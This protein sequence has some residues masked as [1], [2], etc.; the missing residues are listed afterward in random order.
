MKQIWRLPLASRTELWNAVGYTPSAEQL[1]AH[2]DPHRLK[3]VSGGE[4]AGKSFWTAHEL[5]TWL[6]TAGKDDLFWLVGP[7]YELARPEF[8]HLL[9]CYAG[10]G[11][12]DQSSVQTPATGQWNMQTRGGAK[13]ETKTSADIKKLAGVAPTGIAMTE[14]AQQDWEAFIR[15]RGRV[16]QK[17]G[18][19]IMSGTQESS[20][21]WYAEMYYLWLGENAEGVRSFSLPTWSNLALF[22][23]GRKDPEIKALEATLPPDLFLERYGGVPCPPSNLVFREFDPK[24]HVRPCQFDINLPAQVWVDPGYAGAYAVI[25]VQYHMPEWWCIDEVYL[26]GEVVHDV[27]DVCKEREWWPNVSHGVVDVAG[28]QHA[29]QESQIEIW[30]RYGNVRLYSQM[31]PILAGIERHRTFLRDPATGKALLY[32]DPRCSNTIKEYSLYQYPKAK[33]RH[34][35]TEIPIQKDN[36][37]LSAIT[38][39]LVLN[40]GLVER[41]ALGGVDI[42][43]KRG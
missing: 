31:I 29:G 4:R 9:E 33:E 16:A 30:L 39:G 8:Q 27:I 37:A 24:T 10:V 25:A 34:H 23:G 2:T 19:L 6:V 12:I 26:K 1:M 17:R 35:E 3:L 7:S 43:F 41:P 15:C 28:R 21:G 32:F 14:A 38:Y 40:T 20:R 36:H 22:P 11:L 5:A 42:L 18:P 13:I